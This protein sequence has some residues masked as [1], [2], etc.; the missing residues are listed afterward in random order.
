MTKSQINPLLFAVNSLVPKRPWLRAYT[1]KYLN[2]GHRCKLYGA[3]R[4]SLGTDLVE[5]L[6][7]RGFRHITVTEGPASASRQS[8]TIFAFDPNEMI[9]AES[10]VLK[11]AKAHEAQP[12]QWL[13]VTQSRRRVTIKFGPVLAP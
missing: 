10:P 8:V 11:A 7:C 12:A 3:S 5:Q 1:T 9:V 13:E 2:G 6:A 4:A